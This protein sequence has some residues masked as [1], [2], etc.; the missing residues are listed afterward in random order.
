MGR[1]EG[2]QC[3]SKLHCFFFFKERKCNLEEEKNFE[4]DPNMSYDNFNG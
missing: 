1:E 4:S 2:E 3:C